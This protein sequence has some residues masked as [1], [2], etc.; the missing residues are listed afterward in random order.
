MIIE[1]ILDIAT[2]IDRVL[3]G[4]WTL[5]FIALVA[6]YFTIKSGFFQ[7]SKF[8]FIMKG[9]FGKIFE[10]RESDNR[11]RVS[12][13]QAATTSLAGTVGMGNIA[14]VA[15][16]LSIGGP[17]AIFWM[18]LLAFFGM[19]LKTA[20]IT[21]GV[22][23]REMDKKGN[24]HGGPM[25][26]IKKGL[27]WKPL[28]V[29]F[30]VGMIIDALLSATLLQPHTV[31]RAFLTSYNF[32]PYIMTGLMSVITGFVV[33]GG[34]KRIGQ[35]CERLVPLMSVIYILGGIVVVILNY[36]K[37]P[38]VFGLIFK[39]AFAVAPAGGGFVGAVIAI[40]IKNG[41]SKGMFSNEAGQG[42][43]PMAHATAVTEHP[44]EQ[45]IWGAF[46]V[47]IDTIIICSIT[48]FVIL[49]TGDLSSGQTGV[50]LVIRSFSSVF[51][52]S[53]AG[54]IISFCILTFCLTT[55]IGF[56]VYYETSIV[57][58]FGKKSMKFFKWFYLIPGVVFAGVT[59]V[60][61]LWV[62]A[63]ITVGVCAIPNL[64]AVLALSGVFFKLKADYMNKKN[65]YSTKIVDI[66]K[67]YVRTATKKS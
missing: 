67:K 53:V 16:A 11:R 43:A 13:F 52:E 15:T 58:L 22:H 60:E 28:A 46:E 57:S 34:V 30:S 27:G 38:V 3:W 33:I 23:Y 35:F 56:F 21:L 37:I 10:K 55:Q 36:S 61:K 25:Y 20:E 19:I 44:F 32:N 8:G 9:T 1:K 63:N 40:A 29:I 47:F 14:G 41:V 51:A 42:S 64:I 45:G 50:D 62:F 66:S 7:I 54:V 48:A 5:I 31:G 49:S 24:F 18:W 12:S 4:P 65:E 2:L 59:N 17:G 39:Y 6:V 26:Y